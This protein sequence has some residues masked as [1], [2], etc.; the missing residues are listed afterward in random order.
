[1]KQK[2]SPWI[3]PELRAQLEP[4]TVSRPESAHSIHWTTFAII[5]VVLAA[6]IYLGC[7]GV[8]L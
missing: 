4:L 7:G 5:C 6:C 2:L 1:M 3:K 8:T